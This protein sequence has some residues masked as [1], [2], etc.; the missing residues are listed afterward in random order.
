MKIY[1]INKPFMSVKGQFE[2]GK[3]TLTIG[4]AE[5]ALKL[6]KTYRC[7]LGTNKKVWYD[8]VCA[9]GLSFAAKH[10]SW[11]TSP[12]SGRRTAIL[13]IFLFKQHKSRFKKD[14]YEADELVRA[15]VNAKINAGLGIS[16]SYSYRQ[17]PA[18]VVSQRLLCDFLR[19]SKVWQVI[20]ICPCRV[21]CTRTTRIP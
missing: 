5:V 19:Q 11:W 9:D 18:Q 1:T 8:I 17:G 6:Y 3:H 14:Q 12:T 21:F 10:D 4:L 7:Y 2:E 13:P 20:S 15:E 16:H